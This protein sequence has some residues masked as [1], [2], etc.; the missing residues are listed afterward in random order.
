MQKQDESV[1]REEELVVTQD[2][3]E[4]LMKWSVVARPDLG[5]SDLAKDPFH[6]FEHSLGG[7]YCFQGFT[8]PRHGYLTFC[9]SYKV[10]V[11]QAGLYT[12]II[13]TQNET[14]RVDMKAG[15]TLTQLNFGVRMYLSK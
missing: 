14:G 3:F 4:P 11:G 5:K 8:R 2:H 1:R 12:E 6:V 10:H 15:L 9:R 7:C 13:R